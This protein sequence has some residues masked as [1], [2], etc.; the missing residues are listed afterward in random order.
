[1]NKMAKG[2]HEDAVERTRALLDKGIGMAEIKDITHLTEDE[3][4]K[5]KN[6]MVDR[7]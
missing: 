5:V 7:S 6:R 1:M 2:A 4:T 3:I